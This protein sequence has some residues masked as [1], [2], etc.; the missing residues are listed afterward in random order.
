MSP[1]ASGALQASQKHEA[2]G[3]IGLNIFRK[4][5]FNLPL[6][7]RS[8]GSAMV[9]LPVLAAALLIPSTSRAL[10]EKVMLAVTSVNDCRYC[11]SST[12]AWRL[13]MLLISTSCGNCSIAARSTTSMSVTPSQFCSPS[14]LPIPCGTRRTR[15]AR[16]WRGNST[17]I[18]AWKSWP[19][20]TRSIWPTSAP[21]ASMRG[22]NGCARRSLS[23]HSGQCHNRPINQSRRRG[24]AMKERTHRLHRPVL[25]SLSAVGVTL[26]ISGVS[27]FA[28][29]QESQ[30]GPPRKARR[31]QGAYSPYP[32]QTFPAARLLGRC[33]RAHR[34]LL[35]LAECSASR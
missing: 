3:H 8:L 9:H 23:R 32:D 16:R 14:T 5:T 25:L 19:T 30:P 18:N 17:P 22:W 24:A 27:Q 12:R 4:R 21:T 29:G 15:R 31:K 26:L 7:I 6:L 11:S 2:A 34:L 28:I 13:P 20:S 35:R 33:P 1:S 10:R